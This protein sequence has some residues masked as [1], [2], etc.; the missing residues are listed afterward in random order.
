MVEHFGTFLV[1]QACNYKY[2][3]MIDPQMEV[4]TTLNAFPAIIWWNMAIIFTQILH[5]CAVFRHFESKLGISIIEKN[6]YLHQF[7][8]TFL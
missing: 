5:R 8:G 3:W 7:S 1:K 6:F 4:W 2:K